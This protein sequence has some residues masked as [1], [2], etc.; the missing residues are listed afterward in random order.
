MT[1]VAVVALTDG[2]ELLF[3]QV[4]PSFFRDDRMTSQAFRP[5]KK[6]EG[7]L[8][9]ARSSLTDARKAFEHW[10]HKLGLLSAGTWAVSVAE[11]TK[12]E[13]RAFPEPLASPPERVAD[14]AHAFVD[15]RDLSNGRVESKAANLRNEA[16][17]RGRLHPQDNGEAP[18]RAG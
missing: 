16:L 2:D 1:G 17:V 5:T 7:K 12:H 18:A 14:P 8:S 4:H 9:V 6:D 3:R 13:V 10:T 15:F 11:C